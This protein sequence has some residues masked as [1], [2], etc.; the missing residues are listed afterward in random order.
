[1][2][3]P[4]RLER[5]CCLLSLIV[6]MGGGWSW[7]RNIQ[8]TTPLLRANLTTSGRHSWTNNGDLKKA[9]TYATRRLPRWFDTPPRGEKRKFIRLFLRET[10]NLQSFAALFQSC[11]KSKDEVEGD[12]SALGMRPSVSPWTW[13]SGGLLLVVWLLSLVRSVFDKSDCSGGLL[14][15]LLSWPEV[16]QARGLLFQRAKI[17][18]YWNKRRTIDVATTIV[19]E[20]FQM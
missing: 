19:V 15:H 6:I 8:N 3:S 2:Y 10:N 12:G 20:T 18:N 14:R 11:F 7:W 16:L 1:M 17:D 13:Y 5:C 4:N 9:R